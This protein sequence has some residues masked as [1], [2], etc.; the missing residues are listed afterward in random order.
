M[1]RTIYTERDIEE[2]ARK[3][4]SELTLG[5]NVYVTDVARE[6]AEKLAIRLV[7]PAVMVSASPVVVPSRATPGSIDKEELY[8]RV[9]AGVLARLGNSIDEKIIDQVAR[10]VVNRLP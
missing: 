7:P 6:R 3:G 8:R 10:K 1:A 4:V 9:K 5:E 2:M